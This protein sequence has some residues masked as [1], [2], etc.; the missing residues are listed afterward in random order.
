MKK[1]PKDIVREGYERIAEH[2]DQW[3]RDSNQAELDE[4]MNLV[5]PGGHILDAGC[6]TGNR[7]ARALVDGGFQLTGIDISQKMLD[8]AK[9]NVPEATFE[10]GDMTALGFEDDSFDGIVSTYAVFHV[11]RTK[12]FSLFQDFHRLLKKGGA[13]LFSVGSK[14]NGS[15]GVWDWDDGNWDVV[16]MYWSYHSPQKSVELLKSENFEII[17]ARNVEQADGTHF[18]ILARAK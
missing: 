1:D 3:W 17:F 13:L 10:V 16:P 15:D 2:Y 18:W 14:E 11:P 9:H 8:L 6:G 7:V 12:H 4:F 5:K